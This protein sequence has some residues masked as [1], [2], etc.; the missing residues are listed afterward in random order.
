MKSYRRRIGRQ[1]NKGENLHSLRR[2]LAYATRARYAD[3]TTPGKA[4]RCGV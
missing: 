1:L 3:A 2:A 4:S